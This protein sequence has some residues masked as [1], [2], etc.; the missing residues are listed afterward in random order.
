MDRAALERFVAAWGSMGDLFGFSPS[1]ARVSAL[2]IA[3]AKPEIDT[4]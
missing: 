3:T 2:L 1:T 4:V